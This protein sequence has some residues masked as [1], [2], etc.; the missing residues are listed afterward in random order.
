[1]SSQEAK[2][3]RIADLLLAGVEPRSIATTVGASVSTVYTVKG[4]ISNGEGILRKQGSGGV[5]KKRDHAFLKTLK[6][7][8]SE[9]PTTSMRKL[10]RDMKVS[11]RTIRRAVH[12]DLQLNS[13]VRTP[14]HLLTAAMEARRLERAKKVLNYLKR[15]GPTVKIFSDEKI[16]TVDAVVNRRND[17]YIAQSRSEV[18]GIF[19]TKHPAQVMV[20]GVVASDGKKMPL[21][22][23]K[24]GE[25]VNTEVY[26]KV[27]RYKVLP[28]LKA[29][30]PNG[31]YVW[32]QD[33]APAHT[34]RKVQKFCKDN[35][36][37]FWPANFWPSSSPDLNP[38][39][40]A[41]W[42]TLEHSTNSTSH[43]SVAHLKEALVLEWDNMSEA[44]I[45]DSCN[46]FRRRVQAVIDKKG[47]HI[48]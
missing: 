10:A 17:R 45:L 38:L 48:E 24:P 9:N 46:A 26:Y 30:Y 11:P 12:T 14:K 8:V 6:S 41:I 22:F 21:H 28:W 7:T 33:G 39:D 3:Q 43:P 32:T 13:Y 29:N 31:N 4:R 36:A 34:A 37:D 44:F 23:F 18:K 19:R 47:G 1:M 42:G 16:F 35:F 2:R 40:Y 25:K 15:H 20:L 5:N 27:L